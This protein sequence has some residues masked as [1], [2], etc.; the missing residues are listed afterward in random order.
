LNLLLDTHVLLWWFTRDARLSSIA[1]AALTTTENRIFVSAAVAWEIAIK[2]ATGKLA[3]QAMLSDFHGL[4]LQRGFRRLA[5]TTDHA[6][7]A[8]L[9]PPV[10]KDPFDRM[11]AAQSQALNFPVIT[12]DPIFDRY[13]IQRIW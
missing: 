8:G 6:L 9:L 12:A 10:H 11:L 2:T 5:I 4:L 1:D 13:G 3:G 7:R